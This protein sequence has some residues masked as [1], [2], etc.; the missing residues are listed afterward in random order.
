MLLYF[1]AINFSADGEYL[2]GGGKGKHVCLYELKH[3]IL[4][5]KYLLTDNRS[6][7]GVVEFKNS[8][9]REDEVLQS[10]SEE[11]KDDSYLPGSK[12]SLISK[13][14]IKMSVETR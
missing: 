9:K 11:K 4:L 6:L 14:K 2:L 5:K 8:S 7:E 13:R 12:Y 10:D 3:R 1:T